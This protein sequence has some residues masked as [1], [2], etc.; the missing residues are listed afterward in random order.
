MTVIR[1]PGQTFWESSTGEH[2]TSLNLVPNLPEPSA[3]ETGAPFIAVPNSAFER[4]ARPRRRV[5]VHDAEQA[6]WVETTLIQH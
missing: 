6:V 2:D 1:G 5:E 3:K 4:C